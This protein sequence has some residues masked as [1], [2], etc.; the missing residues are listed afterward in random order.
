MKISIGTPFGFSQSLQITGHWDAGAVKRALGCAA[1]P[2]LSGVQSCPFQSMRWDGTSSLIPSH[3][4][5]PSSVSA[6][7]VKIT[8]SFRVSIAIG[9]VS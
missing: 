9:F 3:H 1:S 5:S 2:L 4:T 8:F 7:L 6:Q